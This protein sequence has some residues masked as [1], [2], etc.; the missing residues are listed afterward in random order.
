MD[1][2]VTPT[3][4]SIAPGA[5]QVITVNADVRRVPSDAWA[6]GE[7]QLVPNTTAIPPA[8]LPVAARA[9]NGSS[10]DVLTKSANIDLVQVGSNIHYTVNLTHK[11]LASASYSLSDPIPA[12][13]SYVNGSATGGL[14]YNSGSSTLT[15]SGSIPAGDFVI[16][17]G[18]KTG[19]LSMADL[20]A[21]PANK[22]SSL[23]AGCFLVTLNNLVYFGT[24]YTQGV[25]SVNG[26]M[27]VG[28]PLSCAGNT[29]GQVPA[30]ASPNGTLAPWWD[31]LDF[32]S[33]GNWYFVGV[34]WNGKPH[35]V[36]SW[37]NV[38]VKGTA[39]LVSFQLWFEEGK[40][41]VWFTYKPGSMPAGSPTA[42]V[43]AE[44]AA[45]N[46][47]AT[48][49]YNGTGTV[50][51]G[52]VDLILGPLP[53]VQSFGFD[54]TANAVPGVLNEASVTQSTTTHT[55]YDYTSVY[56]ANT[57]LGG[58]TAWGT[59]CQLVAQRGP[60]QLGL[61]DDPH[62]PKRW[63]DAAAF[64]ERRGLWADPAAW[65]QPGS[66]CVQPER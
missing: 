34:T 36:F 23:D 22:P 11:S 50:P 61:G 19:Y 40:D 65:R 7:I 46:D 49:Y 66:C 51:T 15:W 41:N 13:A 8:H 52:A 9:N 57:W 24:T 39:D 56:R 21:P 48:Y 58:T 6:F 60:G 27:H 42:T 17:E 14:T 2:T 32:T 64:G 18:T 37:E 12:N 1:L 62:H 26:T 53:V 29:N 45:G 28:G 3:S 4:F 44:N 35:T 16:S 63:A 33:G 31:D 43:G 10:S 59:A 54:L 47:G 25:W 38:P 20:G 5:T 55:A 30:T